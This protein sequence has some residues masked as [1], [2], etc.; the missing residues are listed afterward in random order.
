MGGLGFAALF[1]RIR[2]QLPTAVGLSAKTFDCVRVN[3]VAAIPVR[4]VIECELSAR[5]DIAQGEKREVV[6]KVIGVVRGVD[7][8]DYAVRI[9]RVVHKPC[10]G[11]EFLPIDHVEIVVVFAVHLDHVTVVSVVIES[12]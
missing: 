6:H 11:A 8:G 1:T 9:A 3:L 7:G 5:G 10:R 12:E 4:V 2:P